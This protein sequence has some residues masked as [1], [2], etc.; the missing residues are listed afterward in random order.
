MSDINL[1]L[2]SISVSDLD[3]LALADAADGVVNN[4]EKLDLL[5]E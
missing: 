3:R 4:D 2:E 5:A 1:T